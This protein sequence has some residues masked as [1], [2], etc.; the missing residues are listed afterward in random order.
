MICYNIKNVKGEKIM[1]TENENAIYEDDLTGLK[2]E[3]V[4]EKSLLSQ[5][6]KKLRYL[7]RFFAECSFYVYLC[8]RICGEICLL[9]T[10]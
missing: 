2:Q 5:N 8:G 4:S 6:S 1:S 9:A 10:T 3:I 7:S